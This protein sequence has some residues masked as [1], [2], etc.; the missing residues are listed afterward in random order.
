MKPTELTNGEI[1][2]FINGKP[3]TF[4]F[5]MLAAKLV[6]KHGEGLTGNI[7]TIALTL[8]A[9]LMCRFDQ[10]ALAD[11]FKVDD[12]YE[13]MDAM[14]DEDLAKVLVASRSAFERLPNVS[15][16]VNGLLGLGEDGNPLTGKPSKKPDTK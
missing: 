9:G 13:L 4:K 2:V 5:G 1:V 6:E 15:A 12:V 11:N 16:R 14:S 8:W 7:E 10:N 3:F